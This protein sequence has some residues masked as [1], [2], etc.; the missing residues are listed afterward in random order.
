MKYSLIVLSLLLAG[1]AFTQPEITGTLKSTV[2]YWGAKGDGKT[3]DTKAIQ[4]AIDNTKGVLYFPPGAYVISKGLT[5]NSDNVVLMGS[6]KNTASV[7]V[8]TANVDAITLNGIRCTVDGLAIDGNKTCK[9]GIVING[10]QSEVANSIIQ[11]CKGNGINA[12]Y[13]QGQNHNKNIRNCKVYTCRQAGIVVSSN[14][15]Y[16]RDCEIANNEGNQ[17]VILAGAN[18]R[19]YN[20]HIWSGDQFNPNPN[21]VGIEIRGDGFQVQGCVLDR[22]NSYGISINPNPQ[23]TV[24]SGIILGNWFY[25]NGSDLHSTVKSQKIIIEHNSFQ[26]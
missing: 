22:N 21:T 3:D 12:P 17:Q 2:T 6:G 9:D 1:Y 13:V 7:L 24:G 20:C 4:K 16:I 15:M 10:T 25:Q 11:N 8:L 26:Q 19:M 5:V 18:N 14:D 23:Q